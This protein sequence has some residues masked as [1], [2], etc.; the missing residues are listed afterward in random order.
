MYYR[1][2]ANKGIYPYV[3]NEAVCCNEEK[4]C[5]LSNNQTGGVCKPKM[6]I[7]VILFATEKKQVGRGQQFIFEPK[8]IEIAEECIC[9]LKIDYDDYYDD[10][11]DYATTTA[12]MTKNATASSGH[13]AS[14]ALASPLLFVPLFLLHVE[15]LLSLFKQ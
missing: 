1:G 13:A 11:Y 7:K 5:P 6:G 15:N 3:V 2:E 12:T 10:Y 14:S 4:S 8:R 9:E